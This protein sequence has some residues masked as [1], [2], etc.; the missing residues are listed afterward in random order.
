M[1]DYGLS[2]RVALITGIN[3]PQGIGAATALAFAREGAKLVLVYKKVDRPF[4]IDKTDKNG[5]DRY[6]AA[7]AG[8][9]DYLEERLRETKTEYLILER[10]IS[11]EDAVKE[12]YTSAFER[13][14]RVDILVNNAATDDETGCDTIE[15]VTQ[16]VINDTFAVNVRGSLLMIREFVKHRGDYGRILN[17]STDAAQIFAGQITYGASKATMEALTRSIALEVAKYGITVNCIAPGPTQTGWIDEDFEK[18]VIPLIP[19]GELIRPQDIAETML[20]LASKQARMITG[21]VI[22]VS[23]GKAL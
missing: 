9:A 5:V 4:D 7:N 20:F 8:N 3:N 23:G 12:I 11:H 15:A 17:V 16:N 2:G 13:F 21:Q 19:M 18:V 14:G 6:Y 22:K 1:V 10:D